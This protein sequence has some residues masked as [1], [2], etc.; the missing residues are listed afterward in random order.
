M[1]EKILTDA[2]KKS[3]TERGGSS[4]KVISLHQLKQILNSLSDGWISVEDELPIGHDFVLVHK[5]QEGCFVCLFVK[6]ECTFYE[7]DT[8][9]GEYG[10][11]VNP[12]H[13]QPLPAPP[14]DN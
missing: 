13:W 14:E 1:K 6:D 2:K 3:W 9:A 11:V 12:T 5:K 4:I 10:I 8:E 7:W